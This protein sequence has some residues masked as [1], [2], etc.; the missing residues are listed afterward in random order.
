MK[1]LL[2]FVLLVVLFASCK[3]KTNIDYVKEEF[4]NYVETDF[5][6]P[7]EFEEITSIEVTDTIS[8]KL[9]LETIKNMETVSILLGKSNV[10]KLAEYKREFEAD[11]TCIVT[12]EVKVRIKRNGRKS[13]L[14]YYVIDDGLNYKV[15]DHKLGKYEVPELYINFFKFAE[16]VVD[17]RLY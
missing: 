12:Y 13:V 9:V 8:N 11:E 15:Q 2:T 4:M 17:S 6:D 1:Q 16:K 5:D 14:T 7:S 3:E 10:E